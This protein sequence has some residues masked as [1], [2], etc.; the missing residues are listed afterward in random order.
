MASL[1]A[2]VGLGAGVHVVAS[3]VVWGVCASPST[4]GAATTTIKRFVKWVCVM[5]G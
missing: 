4:S 1:E 3:T 5:S 2:L